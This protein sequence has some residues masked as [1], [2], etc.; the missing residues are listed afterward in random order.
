ME[1]VYEFLKNSQVY[2]LATVEGEQ[3]RVRPFGTVDLFEGK[4]Y[5]QTGLKKDVA[6]QMLANPKI[7]I[8]AMYEGRWIRIAAEAVLD[9]RIEAQE[10]LLAAYPNLR[11][12]YEPGDGNTA[13]FYLK[14]AVA[15]ICS[16]T[17]E[18]KTI[19]F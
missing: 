7:E 9:E 8:S 3:P 4:L 1:E 19:R 5:I 16:F 18:T 13:V 2:Y 11:A 14:D 15:D 10:H 17:E 12:M 6:R